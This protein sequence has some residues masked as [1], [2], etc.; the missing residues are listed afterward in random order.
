MYL[1]ALSK[2]LVATTAIVFLFP[3]VARAGVIA[4]WSFDE[5]SGPTAFAAVGSVD[6]TLSG[7]AGFI[8]DGVSGGAAHMSKAGNGLID[9]GD[10][11][12]FTGNSTFS[13]VAWFRIA[14]NDTDGHIIAGRHRRGTANGY[15]LSVNDIDSSSGEVDGGAMFY[16][17][18]PN[19]ITADLGLNDGDWH[20]LVGVH[21]FAGSETRLFV[22]GVLLDAVA[23]D[24]VPASDGNFAVGGI[25]DR[26]GTE[27]VSTLTGDVDEVSLWDHALTA[28][29]VAAL[30]HNPAVG[31]PAPVSEP[32]TLTVLISGLLL[33]GFARR[34]RRARPLDG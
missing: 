1:K 24:S 18:Y 9:M 4:A 3:S 34:R 23:F 30:Y 17:A 31:G 28:D 11:F 33:A 20:Q 10:T 22:D 32:S 25:R 12:G 21:D 19:P 7:D 15:L 29:E 5:T 26:I 14:D 13:L 6:G 8:A 2:S 16:Q 27:M